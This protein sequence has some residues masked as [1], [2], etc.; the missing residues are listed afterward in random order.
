MKYKY[1]ISMYS[2]FHYKDSMVVRPSY[3]YNRNSY[4]GKMASNHHDGSKAIFLSRR[5]S[6]SRQCDS[7]KM[8]TAPP[9]RSSTF[10]LP[11]NTFIWID[12]HIARI[13][14]C[15][16][17]PIFYKLHVDFIHMSFKQI[18]ANYQSR[19]WA[20]ICIWYSLVAWYSFWMKSWIY[21]LL[22]K[23]SESC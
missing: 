22:S 14:I 2:Q 7:A 10:I 5:R 1:H 12:V 3:L 23:Q 18:Q 13:K 9:A 20:I 8:K 4:A 11:I 6:I 21:A 15:E 19:S 16:T 17:P